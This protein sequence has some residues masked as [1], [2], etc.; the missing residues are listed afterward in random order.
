[1]DLVTIILTTLNSEKFIARS[2][3]S[4]LNQTYPEIELIIVDGGSR[5]RTIEIVQGYS[6]PR[7]RVVHQRD[8]SG[9]LPGAINLGMANARGQY[10]TWTQ[11]DSWYEPNAIETL[12]NYLET[13]GEIALVYTDFW[14]VDENGKRLEYRSVNT[15]EYILK[16]DVV[17]QCFLFRRQVYDTVGPQDTQYFP[18]HE[19]PWRVKI[20]SLFQI[21]PLHRALMYWTLHPASLTGR[22]GPWK[23]QY[24]MLEALFQEGLLDRRTHSRQ[25]AE[26]HIHNAYEDFILRADY[27]GFWRHLIAGLGCDA[28]YIRN[29][30]LCKLML[31]SL[32][33]GRRRY[34][35]KLY[36]SWKEDFDARQAQLIRNCASG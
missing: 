14:V 23:I 22:Y 16:E 18:V 33:P 19:V 35:E 15:S 28:R 7:L 32:L 36:G 27:L 2:I 17:G 8:N 6:D 5:D 13:H 20:S 9:K 4:C 10:I 26:T 29:R 21:E 12:L 30:G 25:L 24:M 11:D 3:E 34:R 31:L 1:M